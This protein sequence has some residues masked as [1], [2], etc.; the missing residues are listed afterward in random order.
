MARKKNGWNAQ[1]V[2]IA[3][4]LAMLVL[5]GVW[6][7]LSAP[8]YPNAYM[9][10]MARMMMG[11]A[12]GVD[13]ASLDDNDFERLGDDMMGQMIGDEQL[14]EQMD[15]QMRDERTMHILMARM[16]TGCR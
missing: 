10:P 9:M 3:G 1:L 2:F 4:M 15:A 16:M 12:R 7:Y 13:C 5:L 8:T 11:S 6:N 14:H